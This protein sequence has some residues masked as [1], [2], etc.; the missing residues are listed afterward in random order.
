MPSSHFCL[1]GL[2]PQAKLPEFLLLL[3]VGKLPSF[4]LNDDLKGT[5]ANQRL[6][7]ILRIF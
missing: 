5:K 7:T 4:D 1:R 6:Q 2:A 3:L